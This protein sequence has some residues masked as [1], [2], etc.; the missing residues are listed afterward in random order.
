MAL[1]LVGAAFAEDK[2][3][4]APDPGLADRVAAAQAKLKAK[5]AAATQAIVSDDPA[6]LKGIILDQKQQIELLKAQV[7]KLTQEI[8][9]TKNNGQLGAGVKSWEYGTLSEMPTISVFKWDARPTRAAIE[10]KSLEELYKKIGGT[11]TL[12]EGGR[13]VLFNLLGSQG[14]ELVEKEVRLN[15]DLVMTKFKRPK[16]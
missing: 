6:V 13:V 15:G 3:A 8:A 16:G 1:A 7:G 9:A 5:T 10:A 12:P 4:P 14:W 11:G 2:P